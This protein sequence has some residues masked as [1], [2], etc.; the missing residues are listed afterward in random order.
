MTCVYVCVCVLFTAGSP[1]NRRCRRQNRC[2]INVYGRKAW[3]TPK[4][5]PF[6]IFSTLVRHG[7][8]FQSIPEHR[9]SRPLWEC[10]V[11][12]RNLIFI[13]FPENSDETSSTA[14]CR[15]KCGIHAALY[16][17]AETSQCLRFLQ[18]KSNHSVCVTGHVAHD[19]SFW[20]NSCF[21]TFPVAPQPP[22]K[23]SGQKVVLGV[24][25]FSLTCI[26][27]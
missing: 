9:C 17:L 4:L 21:T 1:T 10:E 19:K 3:M 25:W 6:S 27:L 12:P 7:N 16:C 15:P 18:A 2:W 13:H 20:N 14:A 11:T 26:A 5:V 8:C 23:L 22:P 24:N